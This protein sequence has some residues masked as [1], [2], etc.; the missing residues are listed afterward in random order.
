MAQYIKSIKAEGVLG[1]FDF[2][3]EFQPGVNVLYG[4]NGTGKT[5]L[6]HILANLLNGDYKRFAFIDFKNID[7]VLGDEKKVHL[8][9]EVIEGNIYLNLAIDNNSIVTRYPRDEI[10]TQNS[11]IPS[12]MQMIKIA[13]SIRVKLDRLIHLNNEDTE[14]G[15]GILSSTIWSEIPILSVAY[16]PAFRTMIE[17][18]VASADS[19]TG[20][21]ENMQSLS[22]KLARESFGD[23]V[24]DLNYPSLLEIDR[25]FKSEIDTALLKIAQVDR[26]NF[27][28]LVP[29]ILQALSQKP[30]K[31]Q[32]TPSEVELS[33]TL[34]QI[35]DLIDQ[36][37]ASIYKFSANSLEISTITQLR[38][39][40][41]SFQVDSESMRITAPVLRIYRQALQ[42]IIDMQEN[43]L[44]GI[45]EY[46]HSVN[47]FLEGKSVQVNLADPKQRTSVL[48]IQFDEGSPSTINGIST[49]LSS[50]EREIVT[51]LYAATHMSKQQVVLI[52]EPEISL[53]VNWQ[54]SLLPEMA[55]Q[56]GDRQIIVCTHSP[57]IG[58]DYEDQVII[59]EPKITQSNSSHEEVDHRA[60]EILQT[61]NG[62]DI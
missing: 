53:H 59:F 24:P 19:S 28:N 25:Q 47:S 46:L 17:A 29:S 56:L 50:G 41:K 40:V 15:D 13:R 45:E 4:K 1:R 8:S 27:S 37:N 60:V 48:E 21:S 39:S 2:D 42:K 33:E 20:H 16:F 61:E 9:T 54:R 62:M 5:T 14:D 57:V 18:W 6:L 12:P 10:I 23:F 7:I 49:A 44:R 43:T 51:M 30:E 32:D 26:E 58:A 22:T 35:N 31:L 55:K 36:I 3:Q 38:D 52:D 11:D 34:D